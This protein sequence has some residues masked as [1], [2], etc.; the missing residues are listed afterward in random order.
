LFKSSLLKTTALVGY[1]GAAVAFNSA[2]AADLQSTA[3]PPAPSLPML[4]LP[5]VSGFNGK[6]DAFGGGFGSFDKGAVA[7]VNGS[8]TVP[9]GFRFGAQMDGTVAS[10][11]GKFYGSVADHVFWRDPT[12]GLIGLYGKASDYNGL[13]G[14]RMGQGGLEGEYYLSQVTLRG[15]AGVEGGNSGTF[16]SNG[17]FQKAN[18][19]TRFFDKID[20]AFYPTPNWEVF[21]GHRYTGGINAAAAGVEYLWRTGGGAAVSTYVE[22]RVGEQQYRAIWAGLRVY[23]D[24]GDKSLIDR[25]RQD[26][27]PSWELDPQ[28]FQV[29]NKGSTVHTPKPCPPGYT[30]ISNAEGSF[31]VGPV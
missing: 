9:L 7:G 14:V 6:M 2:M 24:G 31:C 15:V 4:A 28:S 21:V 22:G 12:V 19:T 20:A 26:D 3:Q 23:F 18:V 10:E 17:F 29:T 30:A 27:P 25:K 5:A 11:A 13:G 16:V 8:V 1:F